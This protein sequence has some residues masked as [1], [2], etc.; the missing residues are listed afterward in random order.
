MRSQS[1]RPH[2]LLKALDDD[3][4]YVRSCAALELGRLRA[5]EARDRLKTVMGHDWDQTA[6]NRARE[7]LER[8]GE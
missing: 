5:T 6:R 1:S 3:H 2:L 7:A 4:A 8:I